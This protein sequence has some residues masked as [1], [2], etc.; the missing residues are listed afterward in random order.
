MVPGTLE[1]MKKQRDKRAVPAARH[2][3]FTQTIPALT[4]A[5]TTTHHKN[6]PP[7]WSDWSVPSRNV[8]LIFSDNHNEVE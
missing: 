4:A 5:C 6:R 2:H 3:D 7:D 1:P 8:P